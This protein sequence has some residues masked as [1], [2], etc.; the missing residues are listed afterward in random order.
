MV[1]LELLQQSTRTIAYG[2]PVK[3]A[4]NVYRHSQLTHHHALQNAKR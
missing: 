1:D 2:Y 4:T 3:L